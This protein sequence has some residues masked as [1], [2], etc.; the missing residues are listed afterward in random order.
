MAN[1]TRILC[2]N[3]CIWWESLLCIQILRTYLFGNRM[4]L[5]MGNNRAINTLT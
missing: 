4:N 2:F 1:Y 5:F 3:E